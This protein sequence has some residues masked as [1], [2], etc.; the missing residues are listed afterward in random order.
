ME[1]D[2]GDP[3][4]QLGILCGLAFIPHSLAKF[5]AR[6]AVEAFFAAAGFRPA[7][8]FVYLSLAIEVAVTLGLVVGILIPYAAAVAAIFMLVAA[9]A[10]YRTS[11][12]RWVWNLGGCE[13]HAFWAA[14]CLIVAFHSF[15]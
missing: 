12:G 8:L 1:L 6:E 14:C 13:F 2:L 7:A 11:G 5:T 3:V 10:V 4:R 9:V 15:A